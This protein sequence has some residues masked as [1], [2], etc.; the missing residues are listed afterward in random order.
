[1]MPRTNKREAK[2]KKIDMERAGIAPEGAKW[3]TDTGLLI[4]VLTVAA[5][6]CGLIEIAWKWL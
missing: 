1:M 5:I 6:V 2:M 3:L 4:A